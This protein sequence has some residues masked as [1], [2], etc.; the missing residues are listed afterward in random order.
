M[1]LAAFVGPSIITHHQSTRF[2][3]ARWRGREVAAVTVYRGLASLEHV[4]ARPQTV[5]PA[6]FGL[7]QSSTV[8]SIQP[9]G[10]NRGNAGSRTA[11]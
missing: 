5:A 6:N 10:N 4:P 8:L 11:G 2:P 7:P 1:R 9:E 3:G